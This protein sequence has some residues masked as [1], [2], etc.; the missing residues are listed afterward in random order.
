MF[1]SHV[2]N[3][4]ISTRPDWR[5]RCPKSSC[6]LGQGS[7][8]PCWKGMSQHR[9]TSPG[10]LSPGAEQFCPSASFP[11]PALLHC[12]NQPQILGSCSHTWQC[13]SSRSPEQQKHGIQPGIAGD[14]CSMIPGKPMSA[15]ELFHHSCAGNGTLYSAC[16]QNFLFLQ[17]GLLLP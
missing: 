9:D 16:N 14:G 15:V 12:S 13:C 11:K 4:C 5:G 3:Y 10:E 8:Q 6:C 2:L 17:T 7:C 1:S